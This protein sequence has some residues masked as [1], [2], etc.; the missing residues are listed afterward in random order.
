MLRIETRG[1]VRIVAMDRPSARNAV[2]PAQARALF[3][4]FLA[5]DADDTVDVAVLTGTADMFCAAC[6]SI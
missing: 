5:F 4:A 1:R 3:D 6:A 2:D